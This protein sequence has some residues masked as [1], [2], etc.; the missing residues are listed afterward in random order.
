MQPENVMIDWQGHIKL[1]DFGLSKKLPS[2]SYNTH[3]FVGTR[4]YMSPEVMAKTGHNYLNDVYHIGIFIYDILHGDIPFS[5]S[6]LESKSTSAGPTIKF[7]PGLSTEVKE[8][9]QMLILADPSNRL[10]G[11]DQLRAI[12]LHPWFGELGVQAL[13]GNLLDPKFV[14]DLS[15]YNFTDDIINEGLAM[16]M[17]SITGSDRLTQMTSRGPKS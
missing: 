13:K 17:E 10:G 6:V 3:S 14:P 16:L 12:L 8:L 2:K 9:I 4:G 15:K 1:V 7:R 5:E 11:Q